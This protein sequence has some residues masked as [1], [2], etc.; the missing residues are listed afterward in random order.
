MLTALLP[1][2]ESFGFGA[3]LLSKTSGLAT[4]PQL[5]FSHWEVRT[6]AFVFCFSLRSRRVIHGVARRMQVNETDPFWKPHTE[7]ELEDLGEIVEQSITRKYVDDVRKRKG[8]PIEEKLV[9]FADKQ[10]NLKRNK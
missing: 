1:V 2:V 9:I 7:E 6:G 3:E 4:S 8:L 10:R 5:L